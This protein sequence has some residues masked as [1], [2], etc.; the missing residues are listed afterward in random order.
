MTGKANW[1]QVVDLIRLLKADVRSL[2]QDLDRETGKVYNKE[3][4]EDKRG[5]TSTPH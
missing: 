5:R 1:Q 2:K 4:T 3:N